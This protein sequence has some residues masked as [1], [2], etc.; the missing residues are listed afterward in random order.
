MTTPRN[1]LLTA[2]QVAERLAVRVKRV[3]DLP[4]AQVTLGPRTI[5][6]R[7]EDVEAYIAASTTTATTELP[8][9]STA[10]WAMPARE[11]RPWREARPSAA[12][13]PAPRPQSIGAP[14]SDDD[15][16]DIPF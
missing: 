1:R 2:A 3:Y 9:P 4:I 12:R 14:L 7:D 8:V 6:W 13:T 15:D 5:R 16:G 11:A 10:E